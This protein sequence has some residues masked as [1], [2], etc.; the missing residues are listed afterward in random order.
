MPPQPGRSA[1]G[2][3]QPLTG[4]RAVD[5]R[6]TARCGVVL[7]GQARMVMSGQVVAFSAVV[8]AAPAAASGNSLR[9]SRTR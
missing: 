3:A 6:S 1:A 9:V 4:G 2:A 8:P 5:G 7:A